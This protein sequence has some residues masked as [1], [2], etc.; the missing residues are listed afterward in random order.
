GS[1]WYNAELLAWAPA[2]W[3]SL[4]WPACPRPYRRRF[5]ADTAL[6]RENGRRTGFR[7]ECGR[8][9]P[10]TAGRQTAGRCAAAAAG[11]RD[12]Y[13]RAQSRQWP[14]HSATHWPAASRHRNRAGH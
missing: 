9:I 8:P 4:L 13:C 10:A 2:S 12:K 3:P 14:R 1:Y 11:A 5:R 6:P 7:N